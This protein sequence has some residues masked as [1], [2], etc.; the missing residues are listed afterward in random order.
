[1][2]EAIEGLA[3][4]KSALSSHQ[5]VASAIGKVILMLADGFA[6]GS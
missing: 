6:C 5:V 3:L 1:M 4:V 2:N